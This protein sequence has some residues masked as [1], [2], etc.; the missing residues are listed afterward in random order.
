[1][2][3]TIIILLAAFAFASCKSTFVVA[4]NGT[5]VSVSL[6]GKALV[7]DEWKDRTNPVA[8][9]AEFF[10][11]LYAQTDDW[12]DLVMHNI[13]F[14]GGE[15]FGI[16][17]ARKAYDSFYGQFDPISVSISSDVYHFN[18]N[19]VICTVKITYFYNGETDERIDGVTLWKDENGN[20]LVA[21]FEMLNSFSVS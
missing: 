21:D 17:T 1:M 11:S 18:A 20:W 2:K 4:K 8:A 7:G 14:D 19:T 16:L 13:L 3:K 5:Q 9:L 12:K 15:D 6:D 10:A